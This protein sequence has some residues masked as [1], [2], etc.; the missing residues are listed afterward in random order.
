MIIGLTGQSGAGKSTVCEILVRQESFAVIDCDMVSK[1]VTVD[2]SVEAA[3]IIAEGDIVLKKGMQGGGKAKLIAGGNIYANFI[4]F[5]EVKAKGNVEA[6]I[7]LNSVISAGKSVVVKGQRGAIIGGTNYCV[8]QMSAAIAGNKAEIKT[9]LAS[10][11][12]ED[13][14]KR[15][16]LL[17]TKA[18]S[19]EESIKKTKDEIKQIRDV[20]ITN[21]PKDVKDAKI[22]QLTRRIARD[23]RLLEHVKKE[24]K[25][26]EETMNV[27]ME[28]S[29]S[30]EDA[31]NPGVTVRVDD[32][33]LVI[34][35]AMTHVKFYRPAGS[36]E[37]EVKTL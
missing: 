5:T 32:K 9:V 28:A 10:G 29:I 26:I 34:R 21:E 12:S 15:H 17:T 36:S 25:E 16:H 13:Y 22:S 27:G 2:G 23:E 8:G 7:I 35:N 33:E 11:I 24:L 4:E 31:V 18:Q 20:R 3:T 30:I 14:D 19:A 1:S 37:I 6:N